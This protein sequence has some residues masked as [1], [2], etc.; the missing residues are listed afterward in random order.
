MSSDAGAAP[1][2]IMTLFGSLYTETYC[3]TAA[4]IL[5][6]YDTFITFDREVACFWTAK[7]TGAALL[8]FANRWISAAYYVMVLVEFVPFPSDK[9]CLYFVA[10][11]QAIEILQF[12]PGAAF[13]ALR[14]FVLSR[15]K[16]LGI[17]VFAL[18]LAPVGANLVH[19][20]YQPSGKNF[21]PFGCT[22]SDSTSVAL[23]LRLVIIARV[24]LIIADIL[25]ICITWTKLSSGQWGARKGIRQSERPPLFD[26]LFRGG[27]IYF[28]V[29]FVL[30]TLHLVLS[31][32]GIAGE[33]NAGSSVITEFTVPLTSILISRF[34]LEL[35]EASQMVVRLD[36][37][38]L[39][40]SSRNPWESAP[41]FISSLGGFVNPE[42]SVWSDDED[43]VEEALSRSQIP[44]KM[45]GGGKRETAK[46][47]LSSSSTL[48]IEQHQASHTCV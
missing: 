46:S 25:L 26:I 43:T 36:A 10:A 32:T 2:E 47:A 5:L 41:S 39:W 9:R 30:N 34:L 8:F 14:A 23:N 19:Y 44:E 11:A 13:S 16:L 27:V 17:L 22:L 29:L 4:S 35:Q 37:D 38:D 20:A 21:P 45:E 42:L 28:V 3:A 31:A 33:A 7:R 18:S 6:I 15:S 12:V 1:A 40:H 24:P 48:E